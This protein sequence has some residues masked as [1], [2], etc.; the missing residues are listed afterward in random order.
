MTDTLTRDTLLGG[1]RCSR[2][3]LAEV[4][5]AEAVF[6][7]ELSLKTIDKMRGQGLL[8]RDDAGAEFR[9]LRA[10]IERHHPACAGLL[11]LAY[12]EPSPPPAPDLRA[13]AATKLQQLTDVRDEVRRTSA[14]GANFLLGVATGTLMD[15]RRL[16]PPEEVADLARQVKAEFGEV[17]PDINPDFIHLLDQMISPP[18]DTPQ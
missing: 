11:P 10:A 13:Q 8:S 7:I 3:T 4:C 12:V 9:A 14:Q 15:L 18:K 2:D 5:E 17:W 6:L 16:L 1:L